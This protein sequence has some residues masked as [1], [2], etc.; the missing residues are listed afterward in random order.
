MIS[1]NY[2]LDPTWS[3]ITF[4]VF[5]LQ[6]YFLLKFLLKGFL[7]VLKKALKLFLRPIKKCNLPLYH[8]LKCLHTFLKIALETL[9]STHFT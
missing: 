3:I 7:W 2:A 6:A 5:A 8:K 9:I 1:A 4:F